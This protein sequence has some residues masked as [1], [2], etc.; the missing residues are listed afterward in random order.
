[1]Y[2]HMSRIKQENAYFKGLTGDDIHD[3]YEM[4]MRI[5]LTI[6]KTS[7][8]D[9]YQLW[10]RVPH[11]PVVTCPPDVTLSA[12]TYLHIVKCYPGPTGHMRPVTGVN[13]TTIISR[14]R[15]RWTL[16]LSLWLCSPDKFQG[17]SRTEEDGYCLFWAWIVTE[18]GIKYKEPLN[19]S[20][21]PR[22]WGEE[23][24]WWLPGINE[25][26]LSGP[27]NI[28]LAPGGHRSL[29]QIQKYKRLT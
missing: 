20:Q 4:N 29:G 12:R 1:M 15:R 16:R 2:S 8:P 18:T 10:P 3:F 26:T 22:Y 28:S 23:E 13:V 25:L 21:W 9:D 24:L 27:D 17:T 6:E 5:V 7:D 19:V 14:E 11:A